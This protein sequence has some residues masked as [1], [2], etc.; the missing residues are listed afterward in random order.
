MA[1]LRAVVLAL[2]AVLIAAPA[3]AQDQPVIHVALSPFEAQSDVYYAQDL[4]LFKK[5]GLNVD[6]QQIQGSAAIVAAIAG[7]SI[8]IGTGSAL[9]VE[10]AREK[11]LDMVFVAPGS[12]SDPQAQVSGLVV[13]AASPLHGARDLAGKTVGVNTLHSIDQIG[14]MSWTDANGGDSKSVKF[15]ET[16]PALMLD[17]LTSGRLDVA[18]MA[19]PAWSMALQTGRV[20]NFAYS[21]GAIA[22]RIMITAWFSSRAW[23]DA[24][25]EDVRT[26]AAALNEASAWAVKN[27]AAAAAVLRKY[28]HVT[29]TVAHE[30]HADVLDAALLQPL[31][32]KAFTYGVLP[33]RLDVREMI[34]H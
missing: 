2:A 22:T 9:P 34:W 16:P 26:F 3:P 1:K 27:P 31:V 28:L 20:R 19:D 23:A 5:A 4:G 8:Q 17:A 7:G 12:I 11:G 25:R 15:I 18:E 29:T 10:T 14:V 24:H 6:V 21:D 13:A 32:D 30:H 33:T